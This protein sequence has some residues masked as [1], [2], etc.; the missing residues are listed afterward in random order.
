MNRKTI[1]AVII[2]GI[3]SVFSILIVQIFWIKGT[4]SLQETTLAIQAREDSLNVVH[5]EE[6][7]NIALRNV[8]SV[9]SLCVV[10]V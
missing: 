9:A 7:V 8:L 5:F 1:N 3:L 6:H 4:T 2:L 10:T